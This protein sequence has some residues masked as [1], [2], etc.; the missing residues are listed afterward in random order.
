VDII[1]THPRLLLLVSRALCFF[2]SCCQLQAKHVDDAK[3]S[4]YT[5]AKVR[6][7]KREKEQ[8][9]QD[10]RKREEEVNAAQAYAEFLDAFEGPEERAPK[11]PRNTFVRADTKVVYT[12]AGPDAGVAGTHERR[13]RV[14]FC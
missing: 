12:P 5:N 14:C 6:K 10:A 4:Q 3:I 13:H 9:A 2:A 11:A 8:E 7:S 1:F